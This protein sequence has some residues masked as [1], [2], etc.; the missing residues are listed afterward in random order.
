MLL[1]GFHSLSQLGN[2]FRLMATGFEGSFKDERRHRSLRQSS[3]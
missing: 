2:R 1:P 3:I